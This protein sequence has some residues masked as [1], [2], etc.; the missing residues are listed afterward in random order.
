MAAPKAGEAQELCATI[1]AKQVPLRKLIALNSDLKRVLQT[2]A[3]LT[4]RNKKKDAEHLNKHAMHL[5]RLYLTGIDILEGRG[6]CTYREE[7][8]PLL[9]HIRLGQV[10]LTQVFA[11]A[12]GYEARLKEAY[13]A[14][15]LPE[16]A[17]DQA[18]DALL[19]NLYSKY[20]TSS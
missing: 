12:E 14:S 16:Q 18:I 10:P 4:N 7:N 17:D 11:L 2:Y 20:L 8:L 19:V 15:D 9:R 5:V 1:G 13:E 3:K 6:I